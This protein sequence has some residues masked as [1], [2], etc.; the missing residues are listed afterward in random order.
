MPLPA[1]KSP[2]N[3][4]H[5]ITHDGRK[6]PLLWERR[7]W[8]L[9]SKSKKRPVDFRTGALNITEA[10]R[11]AKEWLVQ[12]A[13][14]PVVARRGGGSL[15]SLVDT[16]KA[17]PK[18]TQ[19]RVARNNISRL[20]TICKTVFKRPLDKVTCREVSPDLWQAYQRAAL[21]EKG[22]EF[23]LVTRYRENISINAAVRAARCLFLP[24]LLR[25]YKTAG[26]DVRPDAGQ[27]VM[28]PVPFVPRPTVDDG[29]LVACW[30]A[31]I[32]GA[33]WLTVGL[34]RFAGLRREEI[35]HC[36]GGWIEIQDGAVSI[37]LRD[38]PEE[39]WWTKTGKPYRAQV[40]N[41]ELAEWLRRFKSGN[42]SETLLI[43]EWPRG[44][45]N[46]KMKRHRWFE[47]E[48]QRWLETCGVP[49]K[50][51][52]LHRLRSLYADAL[53]KL[54]ADAVTARLA[55]VKAA[56]DSLGHTVRET[57]ERYYLTPES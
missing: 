14:N 4:P 23:N 41:D 15:E 6:Y 44:A 51:K 9:R 5:E 33:L 10:T 22:H 11:R 57:T 40:I 21:V 8:R 20:R 48:P 39:K 3:R 43:Q 7:G 27:A 31:L 55:G 29:K 53:L 25:A 50:G 26:L 36:R 19:E 42:G 24:A 38:R 54:T 17:T 18:R 37:Y 34:A 13:G 16:Y 12:H 35:S 45:T 49:I 2:P 28:L 32:V 30:N 46:H 56:Q 47:R 52:R 1:A